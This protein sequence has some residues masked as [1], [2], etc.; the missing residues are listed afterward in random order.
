MKRTINGSALRL[1]A[2]LALLII[3]GSCGGEEKEET[4]VQVV[5]PVK[6]ITLGGGQGVGR[7]FPGKVQGSQ[8]VN[9]SFR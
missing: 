4:Q 8:R 5:R 9:L 3:L 2:A 1:A 6:T 7:S